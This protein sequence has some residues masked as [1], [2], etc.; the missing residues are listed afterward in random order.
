[1]EEQHERELQIEVPVIEHFVL[2]GLNEYKNIEV[3]FE[4]NVKVISAENGS[5]KTTILNALYALLTNQPRRL[6][7]IPFKKF[8]LKLAGVDETVHNRQDIL[9]NS[10]RPPNLLAKSRMFSRFVTDD[11]LTDML[12]HLSAG[13][14]DRFRLSEGY[15][16]IYADSPYDHDEIEMQSRKLISAGFGVSEKHMQAQKQIEKIISK[17]QTLYLPTYR[18]IETKIAGE[19]TR[20]HPWHPRHRRALMDKQ[21]DWGGDQLIFYGLRDVEERIETITNEI[22]EGTFKAYNRESGATLDQLLAGSN[23]SSPNEIDKQSSDFKLVLARLGKTDKQTV[24]RVGDLIESGEINKKEHR[25]LRDLLNRLSDVYNENKEQETALEN[26]IKIVNSYWDKQSDRKYF[27]FDKEQLEVNI[28]DD[29]TNAPMS[30]DALSSGEKQIVSMF[31]RLY[32]DVSKSNIILIDEPEL[33]LSIEWQKKLLPDI[34]MAPS[35][36]QLIAITHSPFI[37]DNALD[38]YAGS[39]KITYSDS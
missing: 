22:K 28:V 36:K 33:S 7:A 30:M 18:R 5:G 16:R 29:R 1:M 14:M 12:L 24:I 37:F 10:N 8:R 25:Y 2:E 38:H 26:F 39:M 19:K 32:L 9:D 15:E 34:L 17:F 4:N 11:E 6:N 23:Q 20:R 3:N 35:C 31:A 21:N 27:E 13:D